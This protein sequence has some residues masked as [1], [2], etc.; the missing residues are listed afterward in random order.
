M[1]P[2]GLMV[3][4]LAPAAVFGLLQVR[5]NM[6]QNSTALVTQVCGLEIIKKPGLPHS[7]S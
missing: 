6:S 1:K 7:L 3:T 4:K 2:G 5:T